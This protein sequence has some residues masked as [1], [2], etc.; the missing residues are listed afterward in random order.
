MKKIT[1]RQKGV[2]DTFLLD[3]DETE[4][5]E[6]SKNCSKLFQ[7]SNIYMLKT[8]QSCVIGRPSQLCSITV[9]NI[10]I[11]EDIPE[12][13]KKV[14]KKKDDEIQQDIITDIE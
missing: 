8:S 12:P 14:E 10:E 7:S 4:I 6:Y 13:V 11:K 2:S 5:S 3:D 1:I 9:E